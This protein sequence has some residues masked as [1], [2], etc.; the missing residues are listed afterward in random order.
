MRLWP[1]TTP[2]PRSP[3]LN[4]YRCPTMP[5]QYCFRGH[6]VNYTDVK[7]TTC[8]ACGTSMTPPPVAVAATQQPVAQPARQRWP[9]RGGESAND[10]DGSDRRSTAREVGTYQPPQGSYISGDDDLTF[11]MGAIR[12]NREDSRPMTVKELRESGTPI[13]R[14]DNGPARA[15][16]GQRVETITA[17]ELVE[18][19]VAESGG[20]AAQLSTPAPTRA[21]KLQRSRASASANGGRKRGSGGKGGGSSSSAGAAS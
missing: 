6:L 20:S 9:G 16:G 21:P 8:P 4:P 19:M 7:P 5:S 14:T 18:K 17:K 10:G 13:E 15:I 2:F 3:R 12:V 11:D 1:P